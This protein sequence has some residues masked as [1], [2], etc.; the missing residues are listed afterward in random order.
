M[1]ASSVKI[2]VCRENAGRNKSENKTNAAK[3]DG[4]RKGGMAASA[5]ESGRQRSVAGKSVA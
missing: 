3:S 1:K 5:S 4:R 2:G